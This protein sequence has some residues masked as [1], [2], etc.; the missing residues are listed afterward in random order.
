MSVTVIPIAVV[1]VNELGQSIMTSGI[2][3]M[4]GDEGGQVSAVGWE[5]SSRTG[6]GQLV[7]LG[8]PP[9]PH[10][11]LPHRLGAGESATWMMTADEI[12]RRLAHNE[13]CINIDIES[14]KLRPFVMINGVRISSSEEVS[15]PLP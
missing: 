5:V 7:I 6:S 14:A 10:P 2:E 3:V 8:R 11:R 13:F 1:Y 9:H 4:N 15:L 12:R